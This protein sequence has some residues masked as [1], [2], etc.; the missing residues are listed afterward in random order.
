MGG[1]VLELGNSMC[2]GPEAGGDN[3]DPCGSSVGR[4]CGLKVNLGPCFYMSF[5]FI[6]AL[7]LYT[8]FEP[9]Y[10]LASFK[11]I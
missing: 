10:G 11:C 3:E 7:C 4:I 6:L 8:F 2:E 9:H 1:N 5:S